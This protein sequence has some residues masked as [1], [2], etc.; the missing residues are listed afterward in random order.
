MICAPR[1]AAPQ[2][3][4]GAQG[5]AGQ[6]GATGPAGPV[7]AAGSIVTLSTPLVSTTTRSGGAYFN[8]LVTFIP[9]GTYLVTWT[10][11]FQADAPNDVIASFYAYLYVPGSGYGSSSCQ[12]NY[13][14]EPAT[15]PF[16]G[17]TISTQLSY[18]FTG[19]QFLAVGIR[20]TT[21]SGGT[22]TLNAPSTPN[23]TLLKF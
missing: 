2:G 20:C 4:A 14:Q 5:S 11:E 18:L 12:S 3:P 9:Q 1:F 17:A 6:T 8:D 7:H 21:G 10:F 19:S 16:G 15:G 23:V 13:A 22:W